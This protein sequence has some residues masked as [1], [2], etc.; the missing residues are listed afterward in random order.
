ML[1]RL[2]REVDA[3]HGWTVDLRN[4]QPPQGNVEHRYPTEA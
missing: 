4:C 1:L 2:Y 3:P